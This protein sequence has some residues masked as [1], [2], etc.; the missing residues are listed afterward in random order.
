MR[1]TINNKNLEFFQELKLLRYDILSNKFRLNLFNIKENL[2]F[3][4]KKC[5]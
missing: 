3:K 5:S 1:Q 2:R 4:V